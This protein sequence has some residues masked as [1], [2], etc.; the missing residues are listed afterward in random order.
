MCKAFLH[1]SSPVSV[2]KHNRFKFN[3]PIMQRS[4]RNSTCSICWYNLYFLFSPRPPHLHRKGATPSWTTYL[5]TTRPYWRISA[6]CWCR[7]SNAF[8]RPFLPTKARGPSVPVSRR[9]SRTPTA[10]TTTWLTTTGMLSSALGWES[11]ALRSSFMWL[12]RRLAVWA[13]EAR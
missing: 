1:S 8:W 9:A 6:S 4:V 12:R 10:N 13:E 3:H 11:T 2:S 5:Q 7:P